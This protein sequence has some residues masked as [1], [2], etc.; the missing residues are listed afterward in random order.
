LIDEVKI[1]VM[2]FLRYFHRFFY[3]S[4][5]RPRLAIRPGHLSRTNRVCGF[6]FW[7]EGPD[8]FTRSADVH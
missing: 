4:V 6:G 2:R 3:T 5:G 8:L 1:Q 7:V